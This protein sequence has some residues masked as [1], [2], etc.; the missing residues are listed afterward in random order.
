MRS[1]NACTGEYEGELGSH[2]N[3]DVGNFVT[4]DGEQSSVHKVEGTLRI[5]RLSGSILLKS[6]CEHIVTFGECS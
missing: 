2:G 4:T 6:F 3:I 5:T 1:R